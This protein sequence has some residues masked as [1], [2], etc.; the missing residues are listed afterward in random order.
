MVTS[1]TS[2]PFYLVSEV[3]QLLRVSPMTVYRL[4][5]DGEIV[6]NKIRGVYRIPASEVGEYLEISQK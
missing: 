1:T 5:N 3:A 4:I 6:A 2:E